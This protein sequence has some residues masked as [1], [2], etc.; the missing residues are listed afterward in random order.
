MKRFLILIASLMTASFAMAGYGNVW[1]SSTTAT[2]DTTKALC[3]PRTQGAILHGVCISKADA[4]TFTIYDSSATANFP[5]AVI[6]STSAAQ[7]GCLF[8]DVK[9]SSGLTYTNSV[10]GTNATILYGCQ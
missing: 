6:Q 3:N 8:Y 10:A 1:K 2:A 9:V 7:S 5:I 4:G